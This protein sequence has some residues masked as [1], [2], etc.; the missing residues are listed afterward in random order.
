MDKQ[1]LLPLV[2]PPASIPFRAAKYFKSMTH[3][4]PVDWIVIHAA[5][6]GETLDGAE[7]LMNYC[8]AND[9]VA[10][11]HYAVDADSI[12][13][14]VL[15]NDIAYHAPGANAK[16]I[17]IELCGRARQTRAEWFDSFSTRT[18]DLAAWLASGICVRLRIPADPVDM[19]GLLA[20]QR[21]ITTHH[22]TTLAWKKSTH[23]DPGQEFPMDHFIERVRYWIGVRVSV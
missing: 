6:V 20:G 21:G 17:G 19:V 23:T 9:R 13:Q 5:E 12:T 4:R 14:S 10:S 18:L 3:A 2:T 1:P 16:G 8:A 7:A 15:E 22:A 11:W